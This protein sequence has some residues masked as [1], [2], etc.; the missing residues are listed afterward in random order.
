MTQITL[1]DPESLAKFVPTKYD[2]LIYGMPKTGKTEF[3]GTWAELGEV[4]FLDSGRGL[5]TLKT[6]A[7]AG[8]IKH[9]DKIYRVPIE[10]R[11]IKVGPASQHIGWLTVRTAFDHLKERSEYAGVKPKTVVLDE[12]TSL[13]KMALDQVL[14][15]T[16][17]HAAFLKQTH[18]IT[19]P[20]WGK[21]R[22][23]MLGL[24]TDGRALPGINFVCIAHQEIRE[25]KES[26]AV[27]EVRP[28]FVGKLASEVA[29]YFDEVYHT[30]TRPKGGKAEYLMHTQGAGPVVAGSRFDLASPLP[31]HYRSI[32]GSIER[33][34]QPKGGD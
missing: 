33:L 20:E 3:A 17:R 6:A 5:L 29:G 26:G 19:Q 10:D 34:S 15:L 16:G 12:V 32:A 7:T 18:K 9:L 23:L 22:N 25:D 28:N 8:R 27:I 4:L 14:C 24:L 11:I 21:L 13:S 2:I 31:T 30:F 1:P